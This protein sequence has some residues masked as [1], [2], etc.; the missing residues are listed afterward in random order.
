MKEPFAF[1]AVTTPVVPFVF[2]E[3]TVRISATSRSESLL[4]TPG[5]ATVTGLS[6]SV[7]AAS[8]SASGMKLGDLSV[9]RINV[10]PTGTG[11]SIPC[12]M[13]FMFP[14]TQVIRVL[15]ISGVTY[16][17]VTIMILPLTAATPVAVSTS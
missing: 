14:S 3:A 17:T 15:T 1:Q 9:I 4:K 6:S 16:S 7:M 8:S 13:T 11:S 10:C 5:A 2:T 12:Q